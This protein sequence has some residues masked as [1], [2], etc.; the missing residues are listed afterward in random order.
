MRMYKFIVDRML[1]RLG[2]WLRIFGYDT[3]IINEEL[4]DKQSEKDDDL[5]LK[6]SKEDDR[7]LVTRDKMLYKRSIK[8]NLNSVLIISNIIEKQ[9]L[10]LK[11]AVGIEIELKMTRCTICNGEINLYSSNREKLSSIDYIPKRLLSNNEER[12]WVCT[13]CGQFYWIGNHWKM[14]KQMVKNVNDLT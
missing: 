7:I 12:L 10:E 3:R 2:R 4:D 11:Q 14:M 6:I 8:N 13:K 5:L 1:C 9:I